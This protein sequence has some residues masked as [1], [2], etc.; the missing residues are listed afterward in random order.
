MR[1]RFTQLA[2]AAI[3]IVIVPLATAAAEPAKPV[4]APA[5]AAIK[6][7]LGAYCTECHGAEKQKGDRRW[8]QLSLPVRNADTLLDL[9]DIIDQLNLGEM[10]PKKAKQPPDGERRQA[11]ALLTETVAGARDKFSSTGGQTVLR[12]LNRREYINTVSDLFGLN[13]TMF[14]PTTKFPGDQV[15]AHMDNMG[16]ALRTSGYLLDQY[17]DAAEQVVEKAF[18]LQQRP[19]EQTWTFNGNFRQQPE[20]DNG[21]GTAYQFRY[22]C[23]YE[24]PSSPRHLGAYGPLLAF[25]QGV[26]AD[27]FYEIKVKAEALNRQHPYDPATFSSL[28]P[29]EP[30][31]LGI[32]P[33]DQKAGPLHHPQPIQPVLAETTL[34]DNGPQWHTFKVWLDAGY[35]PRFIFPNGMMDEFA[36]IRAILGRYSRLLPESVRYK[37]RTRATVYEHGKMPHVRIHE[38]VIRGPLYDQWPPAGQQVV[39]G[40][41]AFEAGRTREILEAFASRAYRHPARAEEV[42]RLMAV[43]EQ[44]GKDGRSPLDALKD[45]LK[46]ALCSPEFLYLTEPEP[47]GEL[48]AAKNRALPA[49]A[50]ASRLS[51]FLWSTMPDAELTALAH[52]G[53]LLKPQV[54]VAQ[55]KRLLASPKSEA[56]VADFLDSWL[57]LRSLGDMPPDRDAF[58]RYYAQDLQ[59]AMKRETQLF[60][61]DLIDRNASIVR[62][63]DADY[64]FVNRPLAKLYG[65]GDAVSTADG[66]EFR[67]VKL[68]NPNR[69]GLLGQ[70]SVLTVSANGVETSPV[71][72]GVWLLEN[73]LGTPPAPPPDN[74]PAIEPDVRA[75]KTMREILSKHRSDPACYECHQKIDPLGFALEG[76]D[77]IGAS[78]SHYEKFEVPRPGMVNRIVGA[79]IDTSGELPGG[80]TFQDVAGLKKILAERKDQFARTLTERLLSYACGRRIEPLD[81]PEVARIVKELAAREY[82]FRQLI[83]LVVLSQAFQSK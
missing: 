49:H 57:N 76:F 23:I 24:A 14:D 82:G 38:V 29:D 53:E 30:F 40:G 63:L 15:V 46:A 73:I 81:R 17:L 37:E 3:A 9:Q 44:R 58:E 64:T 12:R 20:L 50:L 62:F 78:R 7:F 55:T 43:V 68:T 54:L 36:G 26:P 10:P 51:Y 72:R 19:R 39:F 79:P 74:V 83:E 25:A 67:R 6:S 22:L 31:R 33:G 48:A 35:T 70:G 56:F 52:S 32:V 42:D 60:T 28:N 8:D 71:T 2:V 77:P 5:D 18:R 80:Q 41:K 47:G 65:L 66:N 75:A 11:I 16:D 1:T 13:M 27:G 59:P 21:H 45:G 4:S 61:R 34:G 69:G